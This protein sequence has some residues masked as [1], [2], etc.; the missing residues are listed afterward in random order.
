MNAST[1]PPRLTTDAQLRRAVLVV[2]LANLAYF[3]IEFAVAR[4]IGSVPLFADSVDLLE[5]ESVNVMI[6][7][8]LGW[9][10]RDRARAGTAMAGILLV[11]AAALLWT[12]W[13]KF[14]APPRPIRGCCR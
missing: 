7:V 9:S 14:N 11:P 2:A 1:R 6:A 8:A 12:A 3:G 10:A 13:Q 5:D 4:H